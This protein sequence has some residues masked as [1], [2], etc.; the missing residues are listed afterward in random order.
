MPFPRNVKD[1]A[2][3]RSGRH[4][5]VC[6]RWIGINAEVHHLIPEADGGLDML[7][8]AIVLCYDCHAD[9]G[10]YNVRHPR[11]NKYTVDELRKHRDRWWWWYET[12]PGK[13]MPHE[14]IHVSPALIP[15]W[16]RA[17]RHSNFLRVQN[18][19]NEVFYT[20]VIQLTAVPAGF[21]LEDVDINQVDSNVKPA[22]YDLNGIGVTID[23]M[24]YRSQG[25]KTIV[26][27]SLEPD[28]R[29]RFTI[30]NRI[31]SGVGKAVQPKAKIEVVSASFEPMHVF[32]QE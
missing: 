4:C 5:C 17:G 12:N 13:P 23:P 30:T 14:A 20:V 22:F 7:D 24:Y 11:G 26:I 32:N 6:H 18:T 3:A 29:R 27:T 31:P 21:S 9:V 25:G 19:S 8:N 28:E 2:L 16:S 15:F 1:E 10:H